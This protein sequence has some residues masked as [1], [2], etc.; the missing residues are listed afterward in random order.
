MSYDEGA[1]TSASARAAFLFLLLFPFAIA[2]AREKSAT[3]A[4]STAIRQVVTNFVDAFN[5]H[6]A[7]AVSMCFAE[8]ADFTNPQG[9]YKH[10]REQIE[11]RFASNFAGRLKHA[12][13][14]VNVHRIRFLSPHIASVEIGWE[15]TGA[16]TENGTPIRLRKGVLAWIM[17][18]QNGQWRITVFHEPEF[19]VAPAK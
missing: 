14:K 16:T 8:D 18:K 15:M 10:G 12:R 9:I 3:D 19:V 1:M 17:T 5:R 7:H 2:H 11:G 6:D 4:D 13:R